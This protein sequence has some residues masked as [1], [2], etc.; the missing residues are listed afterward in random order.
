M[1]DLKPPSKS[2][3]NP[4]N[5]DNRT[6]QFEDKT[7]IEKEDDADRKSYFEQCA[8]KLVGLE[9]KKT[10]QGTKFSGTITEW[11]YEKVTGKLLFYIKYSDGDTESFFIEDII[12]HIAITDE[13]K[14]TL[15]DGRI[16]EEVIKEIHE[17][18]NVFLLAEDI[19][20]PNNDQEAIA[21]PI[22]GTGW[23]EGI[24]C[25][26]KSM[27]NMNVYYPTILPQGKKNS[28]ST[29][30]FSSKMRC[31]WQ[32]YQIQVTTSMQRLRTKKRN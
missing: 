11:G 15:F 6:K 1:E 18:L 10:F 27:E 24:D 5:C 7:I 8:D 17:G 2:N 22:H 30:G 9:V 28:R 21:D 19:K 16:F 3:P 4:F 29:L 23:K 31:K 12:R 25:E 14:K 32:P 13:Q 26:L 20:V